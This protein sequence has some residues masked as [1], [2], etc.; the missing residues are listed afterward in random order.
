VLLKHCVERDYIQSNPFRDLDLSR[1]G[2]VSDEWESY[3]RSE[4]KSI[5]AYD[6]SAQDRLL[7]SL[8][9]TTGMRP[10]EVGNLTYQP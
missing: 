10:T 4:L 6:W 9:A 1:L 8:C 3:A 2:K 5:F 7:L